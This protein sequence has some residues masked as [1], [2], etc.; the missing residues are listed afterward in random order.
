MAEPLPKGDYELRQMAFLSS[1]YATNSITI[2]L[3]GVST[4]QIVLDR[5]E[6]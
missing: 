6:G 5:E 4:E 3:Y 1:D 2:A